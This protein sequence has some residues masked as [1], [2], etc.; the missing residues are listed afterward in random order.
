SSWPHLHLTEIVG[1]TARDPFAGPCNPGPGGFVSQPQLAD[2]PYARNLVVAA[3]PF[4]GRAQLPWDTAR[5]TGTFVRGVRDVWL[6]V[7][8]GEYAPAA[9]RVQLVRPDGTIALDDRTPQSTLDG[10]GQGHGQAAF[11]V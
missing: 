4:A 8:L 11:D 7:E 9:E 10:V 5:R 1:Q 2:S 3:R 6:R